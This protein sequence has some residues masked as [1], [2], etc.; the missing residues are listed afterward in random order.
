MPNELTG[1]GAAIGSQESFVRRNRLTLFAGF[2]GVALGL[3]LL[4]ILVLD[5]KDVVSS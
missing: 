2:G 3:F 1:P 4:F 5:G